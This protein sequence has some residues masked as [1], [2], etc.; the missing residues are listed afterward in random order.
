MLTPEIA[1][2]LQLGD[3]RVVES[4]A[5]PAVLALLAGT[6]Q[7]R[8]FQCGADCTGQA[9]QASLLNVVSTTVTIQ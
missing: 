1:G 6:G 5:G 8:E 7:Q 4:A 3:G 9:G 2:L